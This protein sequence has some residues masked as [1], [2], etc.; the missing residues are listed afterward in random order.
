M[1]RKT[2]NADRRSYFGT[3]DQRPNGRWRARYTWKGIKITASE[4]FTTE[5][6]ARAWLAK[7]Q[8]RTLDGSWTAPV[9]A[10]V[11]QIDNTEDGTFA[12]Y[13]RRWL[14]RRLTKK[15]QPIE[16]ATR[17]FY[18]NH[19]RLYVLP[20][21]GH[22][23]LEEITAE[24]VEDWYQELAPN[25]PRQRSGA[26]TTL[27]TLMNEA[28]RKGDIKVSPCQVPGGDRQTRAHDPRYLRA[29]EITKL[30][31]ALPEDRDRLM[32]RTA[33]ATGLRFGELTELRGR[34][35]V[36]EDD[37]RMVFQVRRGVV[38]VDKVY[39]VKTPKSE[40]GKR[41]ISVH[42]ALAEDL[43]KH[44]VNVGGDDLVFTSVDGERLS[45][46][47]WGKTWNRAVKA[48]GLGTVH[49]HDARHTAATNYAR[50]PGVDVKAVM[51][52]LG[53]STPGMALHYCAT[54]DQAR[55]HALI[56]QMPAV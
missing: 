30:L 46:S 56:A 16:A 8:A 14:V 28:V 13:A 45:H 20:A 4:T 55:Q 54:A 39:I 41:D 6:E 44:L 21:F 32:A 2:K 5:R 34:D 26:Y 42:P 18:G 1:P 3:V 27:Q 33:L 53:H 31:A 15:G 24:M 37:G 11:A 22:F 9:I 17:L 23:R 50:V 40:A 52:F 47:T 25:A 36:I 38:L 12:P 29:N 43:E 48:A 19:L 10:V 7:E 51:V 49:F 35:I